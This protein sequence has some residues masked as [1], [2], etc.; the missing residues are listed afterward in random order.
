MNDMIRYSVVEAKN[1]REMVLLKGFPCTW[2]R[3]AFCDYVLDNS[4]DEK[5]M[6]EFNRNILKNVTGQYGVLEVINS[7]SVF[8]LPT[9]TLEE[10]KKI[11][12]EKNIKKLFFEVY[13]SYKDR[14]QEIR[15]F[16]G[17]EIIFKC[18]IET[19]DDNFRNKILK[20]GAVF[21][22]PQEVAG[23]FKS[24]CLLVGVEGQTKEMISYDIE[25][26]EKY[27]EYGCVNLYVENT[28]SIKPDYD[29]QKWFKEKYSYLNDNPKIEVL[30][31]NTDLGVGGIINE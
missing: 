18:G 15:D 31:N 23:Y 4:T 6:V 16:F 3:C 29:L 25:Y 30:W 20:K 10:I 5:E 2:G 13:W 12:L 1:Q 17:V 19:F 22:S 11:V 9:A 27:F 7:G 21:Q 26:L 8:E 28:T 14:L 24:I